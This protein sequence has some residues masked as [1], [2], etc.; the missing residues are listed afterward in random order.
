MAYFD[1]SKGRAAFLTPVTGSIFMIAADL[2]F[3]KPLD[4][5]D[6]LPRLVKGPWSLEHDGASINYCLGQ[7]LAQWSLK[8]ALTCNLVTRSIIQDFR[9]FVD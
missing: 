7:N 8:I 3:L 6:V 2:R 4:V 1:R 5:I 9:R